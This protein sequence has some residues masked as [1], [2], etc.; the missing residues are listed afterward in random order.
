MAPAPFQIGLFQLG[1]QAWLNPQFV[2]QSAQVSNLVQDGIIHPDYYFRFQQTAQNIFVE[3]AGW[4]NLVQGV[5][6]LFRPNFGKELESLLAKQKRDPFYRVLSYLEESPSGLTDERMRRIADAVGPLL[7]KSDEVSISFRKN[8]ASATSADELEAAIELLETDFPLKGPLFH[9]YASTPDRRQK[10]KEAQKRARELIRGRPV[11]SM[12]DPFEVMAVLLVLGK[13]LKKKNLTVEAVRK[14]IE[15]ARIPDRSPGVC[16]APFSFSTTLQK[17]VYEV[18]D[19]GQLKKDVDQ[20]RTISNLTAWIEGIQ[21][22]LREWETQAPRRDRKP[23]RIRYTLSI[24]EG[25][26]NDPD[27][28][29]EHAY[30]TLAQV[31]FILNNI[32]ERMVEM[33][34][35]RTD[36]LMATRPE[37][38][39]AEVRKRAVHEYGDS[40]GK[41]LRLFARWQYWES[42][43]GH[44]N[45]IRFDK[46]S[47]AEETV[48]ALV[49]LYEF[50]TEHL[51]EAMAH[52]FK[53]D[54]FPFPSSITTVVNRLDKWL[55]HVMEGGAVRLELLPGIGKLDLF[56]GY[57]S[58]NC[59][60]KESWA[61][62]GMKDRSFVPYRIVVNEQWVGCVQTFTRVVK[63]KGEK[64][65]FLIVSG[66]DPQMDFFVNPISFLN[67]LEEGLWK[68]AKQG[69]YDLVVVPAKDFAQSSRRAY[70]RKE[71]KRYTEKIRID[72]PVGF[73]QIGVHEDGRPIYYHNE[74]YGEA[75]HDEFLVFRNP[76]P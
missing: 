23:E 62:H 38:D 18:I 76:N 8:I 4:G 12:D 34:R 58:E 65:K 24:L 48:S 68:I 13:V 54:L 5:S 55:K 50:Y 74:T 75:K 44:R 25:L 15:G 39:L 67:G 20:L 31:V 9:R 35:G 52:F 49:Q 47:A 19:K 69:G 32:L 7:P 70:L 11:A 27:L 56:Y 45:A 16:F 29:M 26:K 66:V 3:M 63:I 59:L 51:E 43:Y 36:D 42:P 2:A 10:M 37:R 6:P 61:M 53:G 21:Q 30:P 71:F 41:F 72:E 57:M 46:N 40:F 22:A 73:P 28:E 33:I 14:I 60:A 17:P 1:A 64:R